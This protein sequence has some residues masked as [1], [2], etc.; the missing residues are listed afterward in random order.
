VNQ[1]AIVGAPG[2]LAALFEATSTFQALMFN[3]PLFRTPS[4]GYQQY[5]INCIAVGNVDGRRLSTDVVLFADDWSA[6]EAYWDSGQNKW[7]T[8]LIFTDW[9]A[10]NAGDTPASIRLHV[11]VNRMPASA[12][13]LHGTADL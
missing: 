5:A 7:V 4:G 6:H 13:K 2:G 10:W 1:I 9:D 11:L 12:L 3:D 8:K